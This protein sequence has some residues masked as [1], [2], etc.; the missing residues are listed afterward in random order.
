MEPLISVIIPVWK[1]DRF[2]EKCLDSVINQTY[3]NLQIILVDDGSPDASGEICDLYAKKD[4]RIEVIHQKNAGVCVARNEAMK[5]VRGEYIGFVDPDDWISPDMFEYL[6][7]GIVKYNTQMS[8]CRYYRVTDGKDTYSNC[9]GEDCK[10]TRQQAIEDLVNRFI[11]RNVFWNKLFKRELFNDISFPEGRIYEGTLMI[12]KLIEKCDSVALLG[13]PKYYY[14]DNPTSYVNKDSFGHFC[15]YMYAHIVRYNDLI[16]EYDYLKKT[17]MTDLVKGLFK[18]RYL[19]SIS[20]EEINERKDDISLIRN[21]CE[22]NKEYIFNELGLSKTE[23]KLLKIILEFK[24]DSFKKARRYG[25]VRDRADTLFNIFRRNKN[26]EKKLPEQSE[27][28][29]PLYKDINNRILRQIQLTELDILSKIACVCEKNSISYF[30]YGGTLLGAIRH[31]GFIPWDDDID[32]VMPRKDLDRF[33]EIAPKELGEDYFCQT[34]FNDAGFPMLFTK[35]RY[36]KSYIQE[37]KWINRKMNSGIFVDILPL[38]GYPDNNFL[39]KSFLHMVSLLHQV[40]ALDKPKTD[41]KITKISFKILKKLPKSVQ[42]KLRDKVLRVSTFLGGSKYVCSYGSHYQPVIKR[43]LKKEWFLDYKTATFE[44]KEFRIPV[45]WKEYLIH[46]Y[47]EDY[48]ELPPV[49]K[50]ENHLQLTSTILPAE[51]EARNE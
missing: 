3:R 31:E 47:G 20:A 5:K 33:M 30:L 22:E 16:G 46:L 40:C 24:L 23:K 37:E 7:N 13:D 12:Y 21:F 36:N 10:F 29:Y 26:G 34:C 17:L 25:G 14:L 48:M 27:K 2:L 19:Y 49:E 9:D 45:G 11:I 43:V 39:G 44:G 41:K 32:I 15:D 51:W 28:V 8:V 42:Y 4:Q 35:V 6:Y 1:V 38:D 18:F 50:R